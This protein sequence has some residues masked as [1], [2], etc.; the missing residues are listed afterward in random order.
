M[1]QAQPPSQPFTLANSLQALARL[2][3]SLELYRRLYLWKYYLLGIFGT[4]HT[5][6]INAV[7]DEVLRVC[8]ARQCK[9]AIAIEAV[10]SPAH[11]KHLIVH[12]YPL[13][14]HQS[15]QYILH[16]VGEEVIPT[17]ALPI[18]QEAAL[19]GMRA[20]LEILVSLTAGDS[21]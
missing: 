2:P 13:I 11:S 19:E 21:L 5:T 1:S 20:E 15:V 7:M 10:L 8:A 9:S 4:K 14:A 16:G 18:G 17:Y 6:D 12:E 3:N